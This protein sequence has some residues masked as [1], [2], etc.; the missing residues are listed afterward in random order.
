MPTKIQ[1]LIFLC[2]FAYLARGQTPS[3]A[4]K[5]YAVFFYVTKFQPGLD[6][7]P[8]TKVE[9]EQ[10]EFE[11][12][13]NYAVTTQLVANPSKAQILASLATYNRSL[14]P[15]DRV[16][17]FFSMHGHYDE[18]ANRGYLIAADGLA[19]DEYGSSRLSYDELATYFARCS[20]KHLLVGLD[21]C[22][23][24]AFGERYKSIPDA[25]LPSVEDDC[26]SSLRKGMNYQVRQ[27]LCSG[28]KLSRTPAK[29]LFA[30][31][32]LEALR[33]GGE[34]GIVNFDYLEFYLK[35]I[36]SPKA[37]V[38]YFGSHQVGG[39]YSFVQRGDCNGIIPPPPGPDGSQD[40]AAWRRAK[41]AN[42]IAAFQEYRRNFPQGEFYQEAL[43]AEK[44]LAGADLLNRENTDW[45]IAQEKNTIEAYQ[46]YQRKWPQGRFY[47]AAAEAIK[48]LTQPGDDL[49]LIRGGNFQ[50]GCT[51][52]QQDCSSDEKPVH[53]VT[54]SDFYI[55]KYEVTQ[56]LWQEIMGASPSYFK[57]CDQ[58]PV[59]QVS[60]DDVQSFL[61]KLNA[62]YP[63]RNYRLPTEAE[64]EYAARE[65]GKAV[66]FGNGKNIINPSEI[67]FDASAAYKKPYS[68]AG[69]YRQKTVPVGSLNSPNALGLHDMSGN[70]WEWC[71]DWKE[72]YPSAAQNNPQGPSSGSYRVVRGGSWSYSPQN[73][74]VAS[75]FYYAPGNRNSGLGFRLARTP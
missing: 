74:R 57:D 15:N 51:S 40:L 65:G 32:I 25:P 10:I 58:C 22:Y 49:V 28:N 70:V 27:F 42:T 38:G 6:A 37:E 11:L 19:R 39:L 73:C 20:A 34:Q 35:R 16:F 13:T 54:I 41:Q 66:L 5:D 48:A 56:K 12:R 29:S 9:C 7:L 63:G 69:T 4:G 14:G 33:R 75:R 24:G 53:S 3:R 18:A 60:W 36:E 72:T 46:A 67:N 61:Q 17:Y 71:S 62:K 64:W 59:E 43:D 45:E 68:I 1:L 31:R 26:Q 50:M 21:A 44:R 23:S 55:G 47:T 8:E 30:A 52:E 2:T